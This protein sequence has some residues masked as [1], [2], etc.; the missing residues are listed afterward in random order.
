MI[1]INRRNVAFAA[2]ELNLEFP[3]C[4][5]GQMLVLPERR[6]CHSPKLVGL[7]VVSPAQCER[8]HCR[9]HASTDIG[10]N[11]ALRLL[12]CAHLGEA[13][14]RAPTDSQHEITTTDD[15]VFHCG[16]PR[17]QTTTLL[18]CQGC[19]DYLFPLITPNMPPEMVLDLVSL[20]PREVPS[21]WARWEN[22][23]AAHQLAA[24]RAIA[25][26]PAFPTQLEGRGV[27]VVGG[28]KYF[29]SAYVTIRVLRHVGCRLPIELWH[30]DGE[31]DA[32]MQRLVE[33]W[34]V[35]CIN[36]DRVETTE[37]FR[38]LHGNWWK[39]WQLKAFALRH[40]SFREV[41]LLDADSYPVRNPEFLF[42]WPNYRDW[43]AVF[44]PDLK[45]NKGMIPTHAWKALGIEPFQELPTESGQLLV[46]KEL[47]WRELNLA[48]HYNSHADFVYRILYGDKDTF[49][50]A[51]QRL[52]RRYARMW[53]ES[54]FESVAIRQL[55]ERGELLFLHRVHD[56][57][58]LPE[59]TFSAS[60]QQALENKFH[61]QFPLESFCFDVVSQLCESRFQL[62][63]S[64]AP[65]PP[66]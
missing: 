6:R 59:T 45:V 26:M 30:L 27:V 3:E 10:L 64:S 9:D 48:L 8:C 47:C 11:S 17:H 44:W 24:S 20:P 58:R 5:H 2:E 49:P 35:R 39:G 28:G 65:A 62:H 56:K 12:R 61:P 25:Q 60:P 29:V 46:H 52:G 57:F 22:V 34:G 21:D 51:W 40:C 7:K 15:E 43:G 33:A 16:H 53:P 50:M 13:I 18:D 54:E 32:E 66:K 38:F 4:R 31:I 19:Q 23:Q 42:D 1:R 14:G 41:L 55:D 36:A 37:P 63:L